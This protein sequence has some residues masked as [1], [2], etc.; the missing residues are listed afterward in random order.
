MIQY[1][2]KYWPFIRSVFII[3]DCLNPPSSVGVLASFTATTHGS[4]VTYSC[5]YGYVTSTGDLTIFCHSGIWVGTPLTCSLAGSFYRFGVRFIFCR[6][7]T[8]E[9][10]YSTHPF[11]NIYLRRENYRCHFT[12]Q[13]V[14]KKHSLCDSLCSQ[15]LFSR[16][17]CA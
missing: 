11:K 16:Q 6:P 10:N 3:P 5:D 7:D 17:K 15:N 14:P 8:N 13:Q 12:Y 4:I 2:Q 9:I 1:N